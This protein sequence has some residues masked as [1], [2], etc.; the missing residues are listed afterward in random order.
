MAAQATLTA[1]LQSLAGALQIVP[2]VDNTDLAGSGYEMRQAATHTRQ[3]PNVWVKATGMSG[4]LQS[5]FG[6]V[7]RAVLY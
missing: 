5:L 4:Q 6:V 3:P 1:L 7:D 2:A